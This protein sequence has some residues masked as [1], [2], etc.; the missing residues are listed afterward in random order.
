MSEI[1]VGSRVRSFDFPYNR[2]LEGDRACYVEG[3]VEAMGW[4]DDFRDC[5]RYKIKVERKVW[6]GE[7]V[8]LSREE[9][10]HHVFPPVNGTP[11]LGGDVCD[12]VV[13][14]DSGRPGG[15]HVLLDDADCISGDEAIPGGHEDPV[16]C[17]VCG[18]VSELSVA[19]NG[20]WVPSWW[21]LAERDH[22]PTCPDCCHRLGIEWAPGEDP[23]MV[24]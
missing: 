3:T 9:E 13:L 16:M 14:I 22:G 21:D 6:G 8:S 15:D 4:M 7:N 17:E 12:G 18:L 19:M 23:A 5:P 2:D 10:T 20:D 1:V 11:R 24:R